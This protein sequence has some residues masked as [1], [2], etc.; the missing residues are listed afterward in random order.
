M[1]SKVE[2]RVVCKCMIVCLEDHD[3]VGG[4]WK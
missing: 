2:V 3:G 1:G 4:E